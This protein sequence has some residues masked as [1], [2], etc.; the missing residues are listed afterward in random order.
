VRLVFRKG[1]VVYASA[2]EGERFLKNQLALDSGAAKVGE[3]SLTDRRFSRITHFMANTLFDENYG[4]AY[5]NCHIALGA[6]YNNTYSGNPRRLS[7][8]LKAG[9]GFN[10]SALHWDFVNTESNRVT[11]NLADGS[12]LTIY[13]DGEFAC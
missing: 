10:D 4:G 9:L 6:S 5:G 12:R 2:G 13:E 3:F 1:R 8:S 11:A 7:A